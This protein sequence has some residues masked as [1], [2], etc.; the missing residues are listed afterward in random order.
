MHT[1][2]NEVTVIAVGL[3]V[4][5]A[6][7]IVLQFHDKKILPVE[8]IGSANYIGISLAFASSKQVSQSRAQRSITMQLKP[9][10]VSWPCSKCL[11]KWPSKNSSVGIENFVK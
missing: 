7:S 9:N 10:P 8:E 11:H 5:V 2:N 1:V 6:Y 4:A 3:I